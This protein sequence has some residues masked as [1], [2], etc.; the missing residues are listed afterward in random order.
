MVKTVGGDRVQVI[1]LVGPD[2][3]AHVFEPTPAAAK[4]I[5]DAKVV[6]IKQTRLEQGSMPRLIEASNYK[7][8]V[9]VT[10]KGT[11]TLRMEREGES[12]K[13]R[14]SAH[15][16]GKP[17]MVD[18][19]HAW[20]N[21]ANGKI[22][23][24]N[25]VAGLSAGGPAGAEIY[26]ANGQSYITEI[27]KLD[28]EVRTKLAAIPQARR[29]VVT[30]HDAFQYFGKAYGLELLAPEGVSTEAEASAEDVAKLIR[31]IRKDRITAVFFENMSD[32]R[33]L[34]QISKETGAKIGGTV[35][36]SDALSAADG[37]APTYLGMF[38]HNLGG[39][40]YPGPGRLVKRDIARWHARAASPLRCQPEGTP[41]QYLPF[42]CR[43]HSADAPLRMARQ[44]GGRSS[45]VNVFGGSFAL[46]LQHLLCF[47]R[48]PP[49]QRCI[50]TIPC[51]HGLGLNTGIF[52]LGAQETDMEVVVG[53][54][55]GRTFCSH[56]AVGG[57]KY[58]RGTLDREN[59]KDPVDPRVESGLLLARWLAQGVQF[60]GSIL[61][62]SLAT[63][64]MADTSSRSTGVSR[65][66]GAG[67][68]Q[69]ST[70]RP[71]WWLRW[72]VGIGPP[73]GSAISPIRIPPLPSC[74]LPPPASR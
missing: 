4:A 47:C 15:E 69:M 67:R 74:Q 27:D 54:Q 46:C 33:L 11:K 52:A 31:Q 36:H 71:I 43:P 29:K 42:F 41:Y 51:R 45:S 35:A 66:S 24:E 50:A 5:G 73:R 34:T 19:P 53:P 56:P 1:T 6:F 10:S 60:M 25:L 40:L 38:R 48:K 44:A 22:Y 58:A 7:G 32:N 59:N 37:P 55:R 9:V 63:I 20:Q 30:T 13:E 8:P 2:G 64:E 61:C 3:D 57:S 12:G 18:D 21:L 62:P 39:K 16:H 23:V 68:N 72:P 26:R 17:H 28:A 65:V 49:L 14:A 70:S